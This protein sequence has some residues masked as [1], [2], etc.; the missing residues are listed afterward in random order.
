MQQDSIVHTPLPQTEEAYS[1]EPSTDE[2]A[3]AALV[4]HHYTQEVDTTPPDPA[5]MHPLPAEMPLTTKPDFLLH[6]HWAEGTLRF[7]MCDLLKSLQAET[8]RKDSTYMAYRTT[9]MAGDPVPYR[10]RT[11]NFVTISLMVGF[12]LVVWVISRSRHYIRQQV[13]D[14][15]HEPVRSNLFSER[16][17]NELR[18]Q[19][20]LIFQ[21]CFMLGVL[22]FD[23]VQERQAEV[24]N[25][26]SPYQILSAGIGLCAV[27][28]LLKIMVYG[29]VNHVFFTR[30]Q[31]KRWYDANM[32]TILA[33]GLS[34][35][36][37]GLLVVYFDLAFRP[38][39]ILFA[40]LLA[41]TKLLLFY[42]CW[43]IFFTYSFGIVHLFLYLCTL[44]IVPMLMLVKTLMIVG[45]LLLTIN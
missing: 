28:Y 16:T 24:F 17:R 31:A 13:K 30:E 21:T 40:A 45:N 10:F 42:K 36:P 32:L 8:H 14:F 15:F 18:G 5:Q 19:T 38:T 37:V 22:Y 34:L 4:H 23:Y 6:D 2:T 7:E 44:E 3:E 35:L 41:V 26:I 1:A 43:R 33:F 27:Y 29:F 12:F 11:D 20:F 25:Q 9:G 39:L